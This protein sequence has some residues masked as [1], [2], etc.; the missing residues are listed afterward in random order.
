[1][2]T[3]LRG[4]VGAPSSRVMATPSTNRTARGLLWTGRI[5][6]GLV[7][8]ALLLDAGAKVALLPPVVEGTKHLGFTQPPEFARTLGLVLLACTLLYAIPRTAVL[9]AI[10]TTAFLGGTVAIHLRLD[11][12]LFSHVLFGAYIGVVLWAGLGLRNE[13]VR[14]LL[15]PISLTTE[16]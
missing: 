13:R 12:P 6:S 14:Q 10:L 11:H 8:A 7:V 5:L 4:L 3:E 16:K 9:G 2:R 1:M 15:F